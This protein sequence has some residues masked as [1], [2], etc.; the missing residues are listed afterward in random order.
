MRRPVSRIGRLLD[1]VGLM[2]LT[3]GAACY[4]YAYV[5]LRDLEGVREGAGAAP[6]ASIVRFDKLWKLSRLGIGLAVTGLVVAV[7]AA[8]AG[9]G[10]QPNVS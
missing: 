6:F 3:A 8:V 5:G 2:I 10:R 7:G 1:I 9:R 4:V